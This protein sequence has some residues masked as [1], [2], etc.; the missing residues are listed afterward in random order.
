MSKGSHWSLVIGH[1][2]LVNIRSSICNRDG[3][4]LLELI[5]VILLIS[6]IIGLSAVFLAGTLS[7]TSLDAVAREMVTTIR[8]ARNLARST[9]KSRSIIIN[10][11]SG[12]YSIEGEAERD[13]PEGV[14]IMVMDNLRGEEVR[15][16]TYSIAFNPIGTMG[17]GRIVLWNDRKRVYIDLDPIMGAK[18]IK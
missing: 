11:D 9:G 17:G 18:V 8:H 13:I 1:C 4:T 3:F 7:S 6:L 14:N 12:V 5:I 15:E 2:F 10:L 16:G